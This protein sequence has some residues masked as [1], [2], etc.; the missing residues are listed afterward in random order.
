MTGELTALSVFTLITRLLTVSNVV[1]SVN[2]GERRIKPMN[3]ADNFEN[4]GWNYDWNWKPAL[5][6]PQTP[7][8]ES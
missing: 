6:L 3:Y 4:F 2:T 7:F 1:M 5:E 8:L